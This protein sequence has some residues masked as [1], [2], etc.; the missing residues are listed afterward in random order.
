[1]VFQVLE[2]IIILIIQHVEFWIYTP[3]LFIHVLLYAFWG[4]QKKTKQRLEG[5]NSTCK[6]HIKNGL[7]PMLT[8]SRHMRMKLWRTSRQQRLT[9]H[10]QKTEHQ[11]YLYHTYARANTH[12]HTFF[13]IH[14]FFSCVDGPTN[15]KGKEDL[16]LLKL[17]YAKYHLETLITNWKR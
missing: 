8:S 16:G 17:R 4:H 5:E 3:R 6:S 2:N 1:M 10:T 9:K 15:K 13:F 12:T 7:D 11:R 14:I